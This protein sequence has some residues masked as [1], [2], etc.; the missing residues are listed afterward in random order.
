[1][2]LA[3]FSM[4]GLKFCAMATTFIAVAMGK[5]GRLFHLGPFIGCSIQPH[6]EHRR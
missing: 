2:A 1:L 5:L 3:N 6:I 4:F